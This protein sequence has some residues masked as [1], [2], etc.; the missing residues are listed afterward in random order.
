MGL[1]IA[2]GSKTITIIKFDKKA[3]STVEEFLNLFIKNTPAKVMPE[4]KAIKFPIIFPVPISLKKNNTTPTVHKRIV[5]SWCL[6]AFTLFI[7]KSINITNM[8]AV[9]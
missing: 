6:V 5:K 1:I 8:G 7:K 9:Y 3:E 4:N 2:K